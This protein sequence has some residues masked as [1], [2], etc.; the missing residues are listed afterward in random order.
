MLEKRYNPKLVEENKYQNWKSK[1]YFNSGDIS[2]QKF[3]MVI[4]PPNVTGKLH[5]GHAFDTTIQDI[6]ARYKK[7][8]GYDVLWLPGTDHA[9]I[10][11]EAKVDEKL[12]NQGISRYEIGREA[13][14]SK[15]WEWKKEYANTIHSQWEKMGLMLDYN[16]E[17]FTLDEGLNKSVNHVFKTLYDQGLIY[18]GERIINWDPVQ[19]T[20][21][22]NIEVIY[23]EDEGEFFYFKYNLVDSNEYLIVATT[24]PETMFGDVCLNV[25][26]SDSRYKKYIG[27]YVYN[28][29]NGDKLPIIADEYVDKK[30]GTGVMKCTPAHD[31]NDFNI[32]KKY[33]LPLIKVMNPDATMNE[34]C[35]KYVGLDRFECRK[36]LVE[37]IKNNGDLIK[38]E[39]IKHNVGHSER[40]GAVIE[41]YL[42]K[43]WFVKMKPLAEAAISNQND[44]NKAIE[45]LPKRFNKA[46]IQWMNKVEDWCI[47]RQLWWGHR[48]PVYYH[49]TTNEILVSEVPPKD[50][51]N[52]TQDE[53]VLDTWF[54]SGLWPFSTLGWPE[55]TNDLKRYYP[56]D[57][58]VTAYDILFFWVSR[59]IV[60]GIHFTDSRPF[61]KVLIHGLIR[62][63][64]GRK[65]SKSLGNGVDPLE[66]IDK[67]GVD[68]LRY[69]LATASTPGLDLRFSET[70]IESSVNFLNKV[71]NSARYILL[72][73]EDDFEYEEINIKDLNIFDKYI[74]ERLNNVIKQVTKNMDQ[75]ELG[76]ASTHVY[77]FV[78]DDF[79]SFYIE[80]CKYYMNSTH[81]N[82]TKN[83]LIHVLK[84]VLMMIYP[85]SPFICEEIY[86]KLPS[87]KESIMLESYPIYNSKYKFKNIEKYIDSARLMIKDIRNYRLTNN[88]NNEL[89][90][91]INFKDKVDIELIELISKL[92]NCKAV[93][94][95]INKS[96][97]S[98]IYSNGELIIYSNLNIEDEITK[99]KQDLEKIEFEIN[100]SNNLLNNKNFVEK[101]KKEKVVEEQEKLKNHLAKKEK[102]L[103]NLK[104]LEK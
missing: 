95:V 15:T 81:S 47:S 4:P 65:M 20:A 58:L 61:D 30:F 50:I 94:K 62:D 89:N 42:S 104:E 86:T 31:P 101:A 39:K 73:I 22:S 16:K 59:M 91:T 82:V 69:Y 5:L 40:S 78:Y 17:R 71:W 54:S 29:A 60:Q 88:E 76:K 27:K 103:I 102:I 79:C 87:A 92:T 85:Y 21:L 26:P 37:D 80:T 75:Y 19:K 12:R 44:K 36:Q 33:N 18:R 93:E 100:R 3:S 72:N 51:E 68:A 67:Y 9:G 43:Q 14:V 63:E 99:L 53:D 38:I 13:F 70:K 66:I 6:I 56:V 48:I 96:N 49:K 1:G 8:K 98:F 25:N 46:F 97:T 2:K 11:T 32:G 28:P 57:I 52:Y 90:I 34:K 10:A 45:F 64:K 84:S 35:G 23:Q 24:R 83:V 55:N 77:N 41:P 74:L 7:A